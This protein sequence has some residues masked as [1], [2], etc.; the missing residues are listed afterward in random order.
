MTSSA[1]LARIVAGALSAVLLAAV[2]VVLASPTASQAS[3]HQVCFTDPHGDVHTGT[4]APADDD[5]A[6]ILEVCAI[7]QQTSLAFSLRVAE[8]TD[9]RADSSWQQGESLALWAIQADGEAYGEPSGQL[10][11]RGHG[12]GLDVQATWYDD[13]TAVCPA[14]ASFDGT[15]YEA[16]FDPR[17]LGVPATISFS[18]YF[19]HDTN[20]ASAAAGT[21][22]YDTAPEG[23]GREGEGRF[24]GPLTRSGA[25]PPAARLSSRFAGPTRIDTAVEISRAEFPRG[26]D[27]VYLVRQDDFPD[28]LAAGAMTRGPILLVPRCGPL[29][30]VVALEIDR[31]DPVRVFALGGEAAVCEE[32]LE[33]A[34]ARA[35]SR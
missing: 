3:G 17:C 27:E 9:P 24:T 16:S 5:R 23:M 31:I 14:T 13:Q 10:L 33:A 7:Y 30:Q 19:Q 11:M 4:D 6:D 34:R 21:L 20:P 35:R 18:A 2:A 1:N 28:A 26:A 25:T 12:G 29:P 15:W 22:R 8:P 32:L